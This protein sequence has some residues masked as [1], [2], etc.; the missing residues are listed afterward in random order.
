MKKFLTLIAILPLFCCSIKPTKSFKNQEPEVAKDFVQGSEDIPLLVGME[1]I[2]EESLGFDSDS[3]SIMSCAYESRIAL[4]KTQEFYKK[5]LPQMGWKAEEISEQFVQKIK[6]TR[7]NEKLE[8]EFSNKNGKNI[9]RFFIS[10][11][12]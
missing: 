3:G 2:F 7:E 10:S 9:L 11:T 12:L 5:T 6:F 1:K 8:I 4:E